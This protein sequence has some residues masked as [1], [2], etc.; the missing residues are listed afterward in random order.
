MAAVMQEVR[1]VEDDT[2]HLR[3]APPS[4]APSLA[5][6]LLS[7][8][9]DVREI[10]DERELLAHCANSTRRLLNYRQAFV[11][12][13]NAGRHRFQVCSASSIGVVDRHSPMIRWIEKVVNRMHADAGCDESR[14]FTLPAYCDATDEESETYPFQQFLWSP[15]TDGNKTFGGL[16]LARETVW[17][18]AE[19]SLT[20][21]IARLYAHAWRAIKG[22]DRL[23]GRKLLSARTSILFLLALCLLAFVPVS[24][25]ALAP[26]EVAPVDPFVVAA[27]FDGVVKEILVDQNQHVVAGDALVAFEDVRLRNEFEIADQNEA[28]A[29][30]RYLRASQGAIYDHQAKRELAI[31]EAELALARAEKAYAAE[32]LQ[33]VEV[34]A[35]VEG[36]AIYTDKRDWVGRPVSAGEAII[37]LAD[38]DNIQFVI[39]LP[40][41][42]S[43]V[44]EEG[45]RVKIFLDSDPLH[46]LEARL[47]EA[48]YQAQPDK[49]DILSYRAIAELEGSADEL[50]RIG[51]QGTAQI[52]AGKAPL[53]YTVLRRPL[54]AARQMT[55]W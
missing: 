19:T 45:A 2:P 6:S 20:N 28:V 52:F 9:G 35:E 54:A 49:R 18:E 27:P 41:K 53:I 21:R 31:N 17:T 36:L 40:V 12:R 13:R 50:P 22:Q 3:I 47:V 33:K 29:Q 55:G 32:L 10:R 4:G 14:L 15:L 26:V 24:I 11:L 16:L 48:S 44:L 5:E 30:A 1:G 39:N 38:P 46:A 7:F 25:T 37:Q 42:D 34:E 51:I 8:E 43:I 23:L